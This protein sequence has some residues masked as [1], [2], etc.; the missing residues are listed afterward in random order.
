[1]V[2]RPAGQ[3][4]D[5]AWH[6]L[7]HGTTTHGLQLQHAE[8]GRLP[9]AYFFTT[10]PLGEV[11]KVMLSKGMAAGAAA[12]SGEVQSGAPLSTAVLGLGCGTIAAY[13][14]AQ[15]SMIFF[16]IDPAVI[17]IATTREYFTYFQD[18]LGRR[19]IVQGDGRL[20]IAAQP[21]ASFDLIIMDAFTSDA[22]PV[23]LI[24]EEAFERVYLRKL[25]PG[26]L[27]AV[28]IS[29]R[30]LRLAPV[31][32]QIAKE[33]GITGRYRFDYDVTEQERAFA[34]KESAWVVLARRGEDLG[35]IARDSRRWAELPFVSG[36]RAWSDEY[37]NIL[38]AFDW[39]KNAK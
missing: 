1:M 27:I 11:F 16:E 7:T 32:G 23:H 37:S 17:H 9:T 5:A 13:N 18:G 28:N 30:H 2:S 10:G 31:L 22:V 33:L 14:R 8:L 12:D 34:K 29:N 24:T 15:D 39:G 35:S 20:T 3:N 21:D 26:G 25:K 38:G 4:G 36:G 19:G 6:A